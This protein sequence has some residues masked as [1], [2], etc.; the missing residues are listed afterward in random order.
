LRALHLLRGRGDDAD[1]ER[2]AHNARSAQ[3]GRPTPRP[4]RSQRRPGTIQIDYKYCRGRVPPAKEAGEIHSECC[5][6]ISP[7]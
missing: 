1:G 3:H 7:A 5:I 4:E 2:E 6:W